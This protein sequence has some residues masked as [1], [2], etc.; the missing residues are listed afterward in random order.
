V[1]G[2]LESVGD[3]AQQAQLLKDVSERKAT[4]AKAAGYYPSEEVETALFEQE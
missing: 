1:L 4:V 2:A 3:E